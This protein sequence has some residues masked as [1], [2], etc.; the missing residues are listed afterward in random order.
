MAE[1]ELA[2]A[3]V[4]VTGASAGI[5]RAT[6]IRAVRQGARVM[7]VARRRKELEAACA[8]AGGGECVTADLASPAGCERVT[9]AVRS[10]FGALDLIFS[11]V[12]V[13]PL[14]MLADT[15]DEHW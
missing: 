1:T 5:G 3:R 6:A 10:S 4:L 7:L 13:A 9:E 14:R 2:G 8:Q 11:C 12:G 15:G